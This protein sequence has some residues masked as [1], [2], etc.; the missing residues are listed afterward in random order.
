MFDNTYIAPLNAVKKEAGTG[1]FHGMRWR[2][3]KN[4]DG[5]LMVTIYPE[6]RSFA[7][8]PDTEK[9]S[10]SFPFT[11]DGHKEMIRWMEEQYEAQRD[12]WENAPRI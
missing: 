3:E 2:I 12:R 4:V 9:E 10:R 8:T 11:E 5:E 7:C 1:S 6:P